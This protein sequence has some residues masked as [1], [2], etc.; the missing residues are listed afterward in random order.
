MFIFS[1]EFSVIVTGHGDGLGQPV[2]ISHRPTQP[3]VINWALIFLYSDFRYQL[4][5]NC[6]LGPTHDQ[7]DQSDGLWLMTMF[8]PIPADAGNLFRDGFMF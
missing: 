4:L 3:I 5:Y 1:N 6:T 7:L 8:L 2:Q